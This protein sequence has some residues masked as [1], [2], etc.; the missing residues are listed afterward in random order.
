MSLN[1]FNKPNSQNVLT[2]PHS[3]TQPTFWLRALSEIKH[4]NVLTATTRYLL[5][6]NIWPLSVKPFLRRRSGVVARAVGKRP[7]SR[8]PHTRRHTNTPINCLLLL[9]LLLMY[10][11]GRVLPHIKSYVRPDKIVRSCCG[12]WLIGVVNCRWWVS[13][14]SEFGDYSTMDSTDSMD[15]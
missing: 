12:M 15:G 1:L 4:N 7:S 13:V 3:S 10:G 2:P 5:T 8:F 11:V 6:D 14:G 9:L